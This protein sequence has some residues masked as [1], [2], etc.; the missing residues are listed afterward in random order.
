MRLDRLLTDK[1]GDDIEIALL[2]IDV[3]GFE[4]TVLRGAPNLLAS[5]RVRSVI[6][7][8][9]TTLPVDWVGELLHATACDYDA[10]AIEETG[11]IR[12]RLVLSPVD[13]DS[14]TAR[15]EQWNLL[16]RRR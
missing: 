6:L 2:K 13:P 12:R 14:A 7:E 16:L 15:A 9:T 10:F 4:S 3:E 11:T 8:V 5:R 1:V